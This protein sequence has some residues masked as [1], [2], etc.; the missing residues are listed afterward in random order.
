[1]QKRMIRFRASASALISQPMLIRLGEFA[2][3]HI[4][5]VQTL[6]VVLLLPAMT[7][8]ALWFPFGFS[9]GGFIEEWD[10]LFLFAQYGVFYIA[11]AASPLAL[12]QA[13]PLTV[14]PQAVAYTLDPN[15][16]LYWHIVQAGSLIVKGASAGMLGVYLT[17]NL[18]LAASL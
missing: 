6:I 2:R 13:R 8:V 17:R 3:A 15:S 11:D 4:Q 18:A 12:Q 9:L 5:C 1:M 7:V 16:F 10:V 14:L